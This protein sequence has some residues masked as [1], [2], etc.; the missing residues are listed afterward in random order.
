MRDTLPPM[1]A[2]DVNAAASVAEPLSKP[3]PEHVLPASVA[4]EQ[5]CREMVA[6]WGGVDLDVALVHR[7]YLDMC[8]DRGWPELPVKTLSQGL[9][10]L[11]CQRRQ[12]DLRKTGEG[13]PTVILF[14]TALVKNA[15]AARQKPRRTKG[16]GSPAKRK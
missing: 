12:L 2:T 3:T 8:A 5:Y 11:G 9:V 14:P 6:G 16:K 4:I 13:R 10:K 1:S 7:G 15:A